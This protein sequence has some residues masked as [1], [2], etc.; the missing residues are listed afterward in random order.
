[1][2][3]FYTAGSRSSVDEKV[4]DHFGIGCPPA[5]FQDVPKEACSEA[6]AS[7]YIRHAEALEIGL[8]RWSHGHVNEVF[9]SGGSI[10]QMTVELL[11]GAVEPQEIEVLE[12][13]WHDKQWQLWTGNRRLASLRLAS[14]FEKQLSQICIKKRR[15]GQHEHQ[16]LDAS[17]KRRPKLSTQDNHPHCKGRWVHIQET[18]EVIGERLTSNTYGFDLL[19][20]LFDPEAKQSFVQGDPRHPFSWRSALSQAFVQSARAAKG[21]VVA[22]AAARIQA[23]Q[24]NNK[25]IQD[26]KAMASKAIPASWKCGLKGAFVRPAASRD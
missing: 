16:L 1:M 5:T 25:D 12:V 18:G 9:G 7:R 26:L 19:S 11:S 3:A 24:A 6:R 20:L 14:F 15:M 8:L 22:D 21:K 4:R 2:Q 13:V 17:R 10:L 23:S